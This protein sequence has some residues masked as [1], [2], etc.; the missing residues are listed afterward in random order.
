MDKK[1]LVFFFIALIVKAEASYLENLSELNSESG[2]VGV[3]C[4]ASITSSTTWTDAGGTVHIRV[5]K[6]VN[7]QI[8]ERC[9]DGAG[10]YTGAFSQA[11]VSSSVVSWLDGG[12]AIHIRVYV[13]NGSSI[14]EWAW[15]N[16]WVIGSSLT[17]GVAS[18]ATL[19]NSPFGIRVYPNDGTNTVSERCWDGAG[20]YVGQYI[21]S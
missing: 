7:G 15:E 5:Y 10:W 4:V 13:S 17:S 9:W 2:C 16:G 8:T 3:S 11:G 20:W 19:W 1:C 6:A 12:G 18:S 14:Q 21:D